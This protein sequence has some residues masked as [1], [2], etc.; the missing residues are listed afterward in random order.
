MPLITRSANIYQN[1]S[2]P[3]LT[4]DYI[5]GCVKLPLC[6]P[7]TF[8]QYETDQ[9]LLSIAPTR[10]GKGR[11]L[12]LPN[13]LHLPEHSVFVIDPKGENALGSVQYRRD[14]LGNDVI[15]FNPF[16]IY[17][18]EFNAIGIKQFQTFNPLANLDPDSQEFADDVANIAEALI[19][20]EMGGDSHWVQAARGY[21]E[22]LIMF[23]VTDPE[24]QKK[25][26]VTLGR[27]R[28]IIG[29]AYSG[30]SDI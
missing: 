6:S 9:H 1:Y 28:Q 20:E 19:Y 11:G 15:I 2:Y 26:R 8:Y 21:V 22:F 12:I 13:L 14:G 10:T 18:K 24:E 16:R 3:R 17:E 30:L 4:R 27:L 7:G 25:K 5:L 29:R 23:L